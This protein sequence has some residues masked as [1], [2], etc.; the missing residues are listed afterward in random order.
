MNHPREKTVEL[1]ARYF[2]KVQELTE[3]FPGAFGSVVRTA[4]FSQLTSLIEVATLSAFAA[5]D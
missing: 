4:I 1:V 5:S 2:A 3:V